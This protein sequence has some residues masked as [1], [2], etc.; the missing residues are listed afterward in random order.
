MVNPFK[1]DGKIPIAVWIS[2]LV[3]FVLTAVILDIAFLPGNPEVS[4]YADSLIA[5]Y[6]IEDPA[7]TDILV[8]PKQPVEEVKRGKSEKPS[9]DNPWVALVIDDFGP[10]GTYNILPYFLD[11]PVEITVSVIPGNSMSKEAGQMIR[12]KGTALLIHLPME[13]ETEVAMDEPDMLMTRH[14]KFDITHL[15]ERISTQL[16][17]AIG[18]NSHMG[19][20]ATKDKRLMTDLARELKNRGYLFYDSW[21]VHGTVAQSVMTT[22][23]VPAIKR[24]V[25]LDNVRDED[26]IRRQ[27]DQLKN[28][29]HKRGWAIGTGHCNRAMLSFLQE[30]LPNEKDVT[31][32]SVKTLMDAITVTRH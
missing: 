15:I 30:Q 24:D 10:A 26:L 21:T 32:V 9:P 22:E 31:F 14:N 2:I 4:D 16:P 3:A 29:A 18:I 20:K 5:V 7:L 19:S 23:G 25:F 27:Y 1:R 12:D 13:P 28:V 6:Q 17:G 8:T 11:L